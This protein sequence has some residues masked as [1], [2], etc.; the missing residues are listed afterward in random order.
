MIL[1]DPITQWTRH[2]TKVVDVCRAEDLQGQ[3]R[4]EEKAQWS[5]CS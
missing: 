4:T 5:A 3:N 2:N 1:A